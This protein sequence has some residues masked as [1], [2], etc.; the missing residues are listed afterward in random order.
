M[1]YRR[2]YY[3]DLEVLYYNNGRTDG[4]EK[5][6]NKKRSQGIIQLLIFT[7]RYQSNV[8]FPNLFSPPSSLFLIFFLTQRLK[9]GQLNNS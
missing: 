8:L 6:Y 2:I 9:L 1:L 3:I 7:A 4:T 5:I